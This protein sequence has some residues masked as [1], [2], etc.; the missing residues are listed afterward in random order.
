MLDEKEPTGILVFEVKWLVAPIGKTGEWLP[1]RL[2][3]IGCLDDR[4][5]FMPLDG[6]NV[7]KLT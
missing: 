5:E 1:M 6:Y 2:D 3:Y 7:W 4:G